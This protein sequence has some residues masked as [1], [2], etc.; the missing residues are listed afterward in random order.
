MRWSL[1]H[2]GRATTGE[3]ANRGQWVDAEHAPANQRQHHGA[4]ADA[5]TTNGKTTATTTTVSTAILDVVRLA[6]TFPS[7]GA[8]S[9]AV[10]H[11]AC[12]GWRY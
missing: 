1:L 12:A 7:H 11:A 2:L 4:D 5:A 6:V 10:L 8:Y 9:L 3:N